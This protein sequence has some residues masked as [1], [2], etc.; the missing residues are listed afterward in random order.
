MTNEHDIDDPMSLSS[1]LFVD[2]EEQSHVITS[3]TLSS[4]EYFIENLS[5]IDG[6]RDTL[7]FNGMID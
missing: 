5:N 4:E 6:S 1:I 3:R 2:M 7:A